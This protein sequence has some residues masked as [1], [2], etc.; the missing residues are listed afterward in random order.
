MKANGKELLRLQNELARKSGPSLKQKFLILEGL[1]REAVMLGVFPLKDPLEGL[2]VDI[3]L[4]RAV[5]GFPTLPSTKLGTG[6]CHPPAISRKGGF[7]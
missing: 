6:K 5:N 7:K 4:A 1:Y 2:E 3:K